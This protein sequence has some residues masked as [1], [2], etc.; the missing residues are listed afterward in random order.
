MK[1]SNGPSSLPAPQSAPVLDRD[2]P[3]VV[4]RTP[5]GGIAVGLNVAGINLP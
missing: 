1:M 4:F 5:S 2:P 3:F